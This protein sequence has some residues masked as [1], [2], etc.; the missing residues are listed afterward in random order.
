[1]PKEIIKAFGVGTDV[2]S[3]EYDQVRDKVINNPLKY[4]GISSLFEI[5]SQYARYYSEYP[6]VEHKE[7]KSLDYVYSILTSLGYEMSEEEKQLQ[8]GTHE[9]FQKE[10]VEEDET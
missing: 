5:N 1:M 4:L 2:D 9:I 7:C 6:E 8:D 3:F 10:E